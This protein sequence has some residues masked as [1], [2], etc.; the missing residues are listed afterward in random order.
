MK[1][2][3]V[4]LT[5]GEFRTY[6][7]SKPTTVKELWCTGLHLM[8]LMKH[9][10][11][12]GRFVVRDCK[13]RRTIFWLYTKCYDLEYKVRLANVGYGKSCGGYTF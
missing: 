3:M 1:S 4:A 6:A 12:K 11:V 7:V 2:Y 13:T 9:N 8:R 10:G 5:I